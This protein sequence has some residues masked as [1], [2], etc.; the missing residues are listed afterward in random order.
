[1]TSQPPASVG[2]GSTH[3]GY[4]MGITLAMIRGN[5]MGGATGPSYQELQITRVY[6]VSCTSHAPQ[7]TY[8][9]REH[10]LPR[11]WGG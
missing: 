10:D 2:G 6:L 3:G 7:V 11:G 1:M 8:G 9:G 4:G 5:T